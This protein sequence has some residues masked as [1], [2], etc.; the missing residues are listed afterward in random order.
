MQLQPRRSRGARKSR[1]HTA[2]SWYYLNPPFPEKPRTPFIDG[3]RG[4]GDASVPLDKHWTGTSGGRKMQYSA[5]QCTRVCNCPATAVAPTG[6]SQFALSLCC[7]WTPR[8]LRARSAQRQP[9]VPKSTTCVCA[10]R[11]NWSSVIVT[12]ARPGCDE[13]R[14]LYNAVQSGCPCQGIAATCIQFYD[15]FLILQN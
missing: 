5:A 1:E 15:Q 10:G 6:G 13:L 3:W 4:I 9:S 7:R 12:C 11:L 8:A 2:P 14:K